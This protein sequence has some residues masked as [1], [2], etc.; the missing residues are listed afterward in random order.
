MHCVFDAIALT[1]NWR[2][3]RVVESIETLAAHLHAQQLQ[4]RVADGYPGSGLPAGAR[5]VPEEE[6]ASASQLVIAVGGDGTMLGAARRAALAGAPLLGINRGRLGFLADVSPAEMLAAIDPI[7]AGEYDSEKRML[8]QAELHSADGR[9]TAGL[10][11]NDVVVK[12]FDSGRMFE[13]QTSVDG[14]YVNTHAGDGFIVST[15]T[16]STAYAL[17]CG[18][19]I[20]MPSLAA[21]VLAPICPHTLSD[22]P[23]VIP[24]NS[25]TEIRLAEDAGDVAGV[26]CDG[27]LI[28]QLGAGD[29]LL[30]EAAENP[31][32]LIHPVGYDYFAI[33]RGK[34]HWG[35]GN[36]PS[37]TAG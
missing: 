17:S 34:L 36:R 37:R 10:A 8:L 7:L 6:I 9:S 13:F 1:G 12:R 27:E 2:D 22:R 31:V 21:I 32:Q 24:G 23:I 35:R 19:P 25:Q 14:R 4:I 18:G 29:R 26:T 11:L 16:G 20:V 15:P 28:G 33:L 3:P 5:L 30:V